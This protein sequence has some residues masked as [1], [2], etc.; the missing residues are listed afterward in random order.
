MRALVL[1]LPCAA[2]NS[3]TRTFIKD[4][5][6]NPVEVDMPTFTDLNAPFLT[7]ECA[8]LFLSSTI[9]TFVAVR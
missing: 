7:A 4:P 3:L 8:Q 6:A 1:L 2:C 9:D 5:F